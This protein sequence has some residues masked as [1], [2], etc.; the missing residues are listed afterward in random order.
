MKICVYDNIMPFKS[1]FHLNIE[2][3]FVVEFIVA[4]KSKTKSNCI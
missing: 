4:L 1:L 2:L 3:L